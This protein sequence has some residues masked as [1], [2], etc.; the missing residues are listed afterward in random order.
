MANN[1]PLPW[2]AA[3]AEALYGPAG[4][5]RTSAPSDHFRTSPHASPL[6]AAALLRLAEENGLRAVV[7][8]G[9]GGGELLG[10]LRR[11]DPTI[12]LVGVELADRPSTLADSIA[13]SPELPA[14]VDGLVVA[15]EWLDNVPLDIAEVDTAGVARVVAV[16]PVRGTESLDAPV[17][18]RD[19]TWLDTWWP[20][21]GAAP[22]TRAEIGWPRDDAWADCVGRLRRGIAV[23]IDYTHSTDTRP[24]YGSLTGYHGGRPVEPVPD[25]SRDL[26]AHVAI[27]ACAAAAGVAGTATAVDRT[28]DET[29]L[30]TQREAIRAL[31]PSPETPARELAHDAP[32]AYLDALSKVGEY[33][34]LCDPAGL[35][36]YTWL[37]HSRGIPIRGL[38]RQN[39]R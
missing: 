36:G 26:T 19:R 10:A 16:E 18:D 8:V 1:P 28:V 9:A 12:R 25:G 23:A 20:L 27:D 38:T 33:V 17:R 7:D 13:W 15:N 2:R 37:V 11:L 5:F 34:E 22:G 30:I 39:G 24:A 32:A 31:V 14:D 6:F 3:M 35:G 29:L 4:F 21:S